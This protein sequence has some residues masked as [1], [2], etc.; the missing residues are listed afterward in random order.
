[1]RFGF[2]PAQNALRQE[3]RG[4]LAREIPSG[5]R[6]RHFIWMTEEEWRTARQFDRKLGKAGWLTLTWPK[7][8]GGQ[9]RG[10]MEQAIFLEEMGY[11]RAPNGGGWAHG[12]VFVGPTIMHYGSASMKAQHLPPISRGDLIWCQGFS[13]PIAGS[14]LSALETSAQRD[15]DDYLVNGMKHLIGMGHRADWCILAARTDRQAPKHKG[16]SLFLVDMHSPGIRVELMPTIPKY[17]AQTRIFFEQVRVPKSC[18]MGEENKGFYQM[19]RTMD[20]ERNRIMFAADAARAVDD[21]TAYVK[22]H[23]ATA[24]MRHRLADRRIEAGAAV[25]LNYRIAWIQE[26]GRLPTAE[27]SV[28]KLFT[29]ELRKRV[30]AT[31]IEML[32]MLGQ[33]SFE[34]RRAP[35]NGA[36][37]DYYLGM[38]S[39][40]IVGGT[41]EVQRDIIAQRGLGLPR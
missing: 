16:V 32:G 30:S 37:S 35:N 15:G 34:E 39:S 14:D 22:G 23:K 19:M 5:W 20:Y 4:F 18:L 26:Q 27:A 29:E 12:P 21:L 28:G 33:L 1:M 11:H 17:G 8:Y 7:E 24:M 40:T 6:G 10:P 41:S 25:L 9:Q 38:V 36:W 3:L 31:A 2:T 13:E